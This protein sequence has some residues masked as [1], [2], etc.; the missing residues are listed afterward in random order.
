MEPKIVELL[1]VECDNTSR[2]HYW[3]EGNDANCTDINEMLDD[4]GNKW[5]VIV[6]PIELGESRGTRYI[7]ARYVESFQ[8]A[9]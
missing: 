4:G 5:F 1:G 3:T 8:R 7:N 9:K 2:F 6:A